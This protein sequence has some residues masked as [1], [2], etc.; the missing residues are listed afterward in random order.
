MLSISR[1]ATSLLFLF[2]IFHTPL[3]AQERAQQDRCAPTVTGSVTAQ[4]V[5]FTAESN[6]IAMR[7]E[8]YTADGHRLFD[9]GF[10]SG[11]LL[12]WTMLDEQGQ[13][14]AAG[15]YPCVVAVNHAVIVNKSVG[16]E[17]K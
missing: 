13:P 3:L 14:Y 17:L 8:V 5:R 6:I 2:A 1:L 11:S 9:S 12:D 15:S 10:K 16:R 4:G 7:L